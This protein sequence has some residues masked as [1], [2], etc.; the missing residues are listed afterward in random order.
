MRSRTLSLALVAAALVGC[1]AT[2]T[3]N[4]RVDLRGDGG[5]WAQWGRDPA[6]QGR[7]G[8]TAQALDKVLGTTVMDPFVLGEAQ[9]ASGDLLV[10]YQAPLIDGGDVYI[11][12]KTGEYTPCDTPG[13]GTPIDCG[14][15][16]WAKQVWSEVKLSW[17]DG[18]LVPAWSAASDWKPVPDGG[19]LGGW[20]PVFHVALAGHYVL[21]PASRGDVLVVTKDTGATLARLSPFADASEARFATG[22]ITV[23]PDGSAYYHVIEFARVDSPWDHEI[24]GAWLVRVAPDGSTTKVAFDALVKSP[25]TTCRGSFSKTELPW[26]PSPDAEPDMIPCGSLRPGLNVAPAVGADGTVVTVAR[27]HIASRYAYVVALTADLQPKWSAS[28]RGHL[29][30]GCGRGSMP[31][32]GT[33]GG[34]REGAR[35]GVDPATNDVPAGAVEDNSTASP[36]IAPD[37]SIFYGAYTRYNFARGHLFH[38]DA[39][40]S[41]LGAYDFGWDATPAIYEHDNTYSVVIKDNRYEVGSYCRDEDICP[42]APG[43]PYTVTQLSPSLGIE[44]TYANSNTKSC[45]RD[46]AGNVT[47]TDDH[48]NG[49]EWCINAAAIDARGTVLANGEDGVLYAIEQGGTHASRLFL[50]Q[51]VGAAYTPL[52]IDKSGRVYAENFGQLVVVGQ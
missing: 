51:A 9:E 2:E 34:C 45:A 21:L 48:P 40:G 44:W 36:T 16:G 39:K 38:F 11:A 13:S 24:S 25:P 22:P 43:G 17:Q 33:P 26:P 50:N 27:T 4:P 7:V 14:A 3:I 49:F 15:D 23:G 8:A 46:G 12:R 31:P 42:P 20:E 1:S 19:G 6:H 47:C 18:Q 5:D 35:D 52:S 41:Y 29:S 32:T 28:L 37:G 10:H 30:D